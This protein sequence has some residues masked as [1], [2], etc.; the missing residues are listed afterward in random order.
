MQKDTEDFFTAKKEW[1][2]IKDD[3]LA[4][5]LK[6]YF[7]K[8]IHT[9]K[10]INYIDCFAGKGKFDDGH[11]G[12]P[13][14]A[15]KIIAECL[16]HANSLPVPKINTYFIELK[17]AEEL[18]ANLQNYSEIHVIEG[19][20]QEKIKNLLKNKIGENIFLYID[21]FG[22]KC[23]DFD[24]Y[25][26]Y[27]S[28]NFS[29]VEMLINFNSF[30]FIREACRIEKLEDKHIKEIETILAVFKGVLLGNSSE[31]ELNTIAGG[32]Y[33]KTIINDYRC[34]KI[35]C[36]EAEKMLSM[37]YCKKLGE[38]FKYVINMPIRLKSG[39]QPK[40]R[41][42]HATNSED[43]CILM[44]QNI[45]NRW[46]N[47]GDIQTKNSSPS[48]FEE[49]IENEIIDEASTQSIILNHLKNYSKP[50]H[51]NNFLA[52]LFTKE[53]VFTKWDILQKTLRNLEKD[54]KIL[55]KRTPA[56]TAK[57]GKPTTFINE[58]K[59]ENHF[60]EIRINR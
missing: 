23:L 48:L 32:D 9:R 40:Y 54:K 11:D 34:N 37:Q 5:Y 6:P 59:K 4:C 21:P 45:C 58:S 49:N 20:Y 31:L 18:K 30:G 16:S 57:T 43:G 35:N 60:I 39:Q 1:S 26:F 12:S 28:M 53:G 50:I 29:S 56:I 19:L 3:L 7:S 47:L 25:S 22:I 55:L 42:I 33:W 8:I 17:Y 36:Y 13:I 46:Q 44:F 2:I 14:I 27:A 24:L 52:E 10:P 41:M 38:K 51:M 15:L